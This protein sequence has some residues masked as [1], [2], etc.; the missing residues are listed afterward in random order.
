MCRL[1]ADSGGAAR[2]EHCFGSE[3]GSEVLVGDDVEGCWA[4][5]A[6]ALRVLVEGVVFGRCHFEELGGGGHFGDK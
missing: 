2:Y 1:D 5:V 3:F 4:G 6:W